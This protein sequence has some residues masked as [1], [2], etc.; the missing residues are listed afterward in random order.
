MDFCCPAIAT[1][2]YKL[3]TLLPSTKPIESPESRE[4]KYESFDQPTCC[5]RLFNLFT[6]SAPASPSWSLRNS[7]LE[8]LDRLPED[9]NHYDSNALSIQE[10]TSK[11]RTQQ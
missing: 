8:N 5:D 11:L 4:D 9:L 3:R 1:Y 6:A 7:L 2:L 10:I